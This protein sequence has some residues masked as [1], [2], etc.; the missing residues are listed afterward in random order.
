MNTNRKKEVIKKA[1]KKK[2]Q[3]LTLMAGLTI[4]TSS[5]GV[6]GTKIKADQVDM[7]SSTSATLVSQ[8]SSSEVTTS[9]TSQVQSKQQDVGGDDTSKA[10]STTAEKVSESN[11]VEEKAETSASQEITKTEVTSTEA[12]VTSSTS[13]ETQTDSN[14]TG[15]AESE[16]TTN[17]GN[18]Q[19]ESQVTNNSTP[20]ETTDVQTTTLDTSNITSQT[21]VANFA[22]VLAANTPDYFQIGDSRYTSV[23][24]VDLASYQRWMTQNDF[25]TLK[26]LGVSTVIIKLTEST[27]YTNPEATKFINYAR[28]AGLNIAIYHYV[29]F[30][31][32]SAA[33]GEGN[34]LANSMRSHGLSGDTLIFADIEDEDTIVN[35]S[36]SNAIASL[37]AFWNTLNG[38]GFTNHAVYVYQ[39]YLYRDAVISTVGRDR[40]WL[41]QYPYTPT[42]GGYYETLHKNEG[43]GAWQFA[44]TAYLPGRAYMG[45]I[46][47]SHDYNGLLTK[48]KEQNLATFDDI[49][50]HGNTLHV[51]GWHAADISK[52]QGYAS[53]I[54][55]DATTNREIT[56]VSY[57]PNRRDDVY[58]VYSD[59]Y[60][61]R[62]SGFNVNI[63]LRPYNLANDTLKIVARYSNQPNG[64]GEYTDV[65]SDGKVLVNNVAHFDNVVITDTSLTA[66]GW[67]ASDN[68]YKQPNSFIILYDITANKELARVKY[69]PTHRGD[70]QKVYGYIYNS[71][72]SGFS[73]IKFN[74]NKKDL[75]GHTLQLIARFSDDKQGNGSYTD[76]W[77][78]KYT[79]N[80]KIASFEQAEI[81]GT[82][83]H[84]KGWYAA[85]E[86]LVKPYSYLILYD[87]TSKKELKRVRY[88]PQ[89]R[90]DVYA[91]HSEIY[92][93][94]NS[95][96]D[97]NF[98]LAGVNYAG[99]DL[100]LIAR[101]SNDRAGNGSYTDFW[102][103]TYKFNQNAAYFDK[104][105]VKGTQLH[106]TGWHAA[107][108][109]AVKP[110]SYIILYD[111]TSNREIKRVNYTATA[112]PDVKNVYKNL[113]NSDNSGFDVN[114]NLAGVNYAGHD[115]RLIARFSNDRAGNGNFTDVWSGTY[116]FNQNAAYFDK[117]EMK[118]TQ[119]HV[120]GWHA[121]DEA[122][123]KPYTYIILYDATSNREIKRVN[124]MATARPDVKNVYKNLY[125]SDNS[126]FDVNFNLAGV[127]YA[128]HDLRLIARFSNDRAGNGNYTDVWSGTYKFNQNAA[129]FDK[130]EVKGTQLH[131]TGWHAADEAAV[132]PYTYIILYDATS[133]R[134]IKRINYTPTA[135]PD[136][137]NVYKNLYNSDNSG[138]DVNFNLAGLNLTGHKIQLIARFSNDR[139]G[140]GNYT[141]VWSSLYKFNSMQKVLRA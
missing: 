54:V 20:S 95:G 77:S 48:R 57:T 106:V 2:L 82:T 1:K 56:R 111:A 89:Y 58:N 74:I 23:D 103:G 63:D 39:S 13:S 100:R 27:T 18:E 92:G 33:V 98:N 84:A 35:S 81:V 65:W 30:N 102:S 12:N 46:D 47:V 49:S 101:F 28:N 112:R 137:K 19:V 116:K 131:V 80:Q 85:D 22:Q 53:L 88:T 31:N 126:G 115:L 114:F 52:A 60:N 134:E 128:G 38:R 3:Q 72:N 79:F 73:N 36:N 24:A 29:R 133:N 9:S 21:S 110:Y 14:N 42:R 94:A 37:N 141:D 107:D 91:R 45:S 121:A 62:Y 120:T 105:E 140:N 64:A 15:A 86:S 10:S 66:S 59:I 76:V 67:H 135:R 55:Y 69:T 123:V 124:Y 108:E 5:A 109:A 119:L 113:Y 4:I 11:Q 17:S 132:K 127:N 40:T 25:N 97:V 32:V 43:Y 93:S 136:V 139:A 71:A 130:V 118:G 6:L 68:S 61:S 70:V 117:V 90:S 96:F 8:S 125:N 122:A 138:F 7:A 99:H 129:Y 51:S 87:N 44:S 34:Y 78:D 50:L 26:A 104:V 83:F 16:S 75:V 41:A